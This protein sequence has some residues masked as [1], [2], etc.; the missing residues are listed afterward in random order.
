MA[1]YVGVVFLIDRDEVLGEVLAPLTVWTA[2]AT[3]A[4]LSWSGMEAVREA[5]VIAHPEGF[6][7]QIYYSCTGFIP[8]L[9]LTVSILAYPRPLRDKW[10]GI[11]VGVPILIMLNLVRLVH[12]FHVGIYRPEIFEYVHH[13]IWENCLILMIIV[14]WLGWVIWSE[15]R[16]KINLRQA[17]AH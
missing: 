10:I 14:L 6:A 13:R 11:G 17:E 1:I 7:Y 12:L 8:V 3:F 16:I 4:L 5:N 2:Q 9:S 15:M